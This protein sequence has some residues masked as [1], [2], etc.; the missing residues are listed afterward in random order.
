MK[1]MAAIL[2]VIII[3]LALSGCLNQLRRG[4][5]AKQA[6]IELVENYYDTI[7]IACQNKDEEA[8]LAI[9]GV[10]KVNIVEGYV[11]V[12]CIGEGISVSS[13]D[14]GFYYT[15]ENIPVGVG[16]NLDIVCNIDT[17]QPEGKGHRGVVHNNDFYTE[18]IRDNIYFYSNAY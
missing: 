15:E 5:K 6:V 10:T 7:L 1:R 17:M 11:L 8:L 9:D 16:C 3:I 13:Q 18:Q 2:L 4:P 14:Y 12:Y